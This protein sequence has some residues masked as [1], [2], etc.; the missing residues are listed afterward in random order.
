ME[1]RKVG[2]PK[3]KSPLDSKRRP[4]PR[5]SVQAYVEEW[6]L[7]QKFVTCVKKDKTLAKKVLETVL[8]KRNTI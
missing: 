4:R 3:L 7:I 8:N 2:R 5:H 1:K 6:K